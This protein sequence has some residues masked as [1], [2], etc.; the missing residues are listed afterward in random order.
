MLSC[1]S[2]ITLYDTDRHVY[3]P[4]RANQLQA[5]GPPQPLRLEI[6]WF[7]MPP[8][9]ACPAGLYPMAP[10]LMPL[11]PL[12]PALSLSSEA[13]CA[14]RAS[15]HHGN[16]PSHASRMMRMIS[17]SSH[18]GLAPGIVTHG[19]NIYA[20]ATPDPGVHRLCSRAVCATGSASRCPLLAQHCLLCCPCSIG[21]IG[22]G[23][24]AHTL[25]TGPRKWMDPS[26]S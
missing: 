20:V 4:G 8:T 7:P 5:Q 13:I 21:G 6:P 24:S 16:P 11:A 26:G 19:T 18:A 9:F 14:H 2:H 1:P 23:R 15:A 10:K 17:Y 3:L 25:T 12:N 22:N